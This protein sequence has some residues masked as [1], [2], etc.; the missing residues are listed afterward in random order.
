[1]GTAPA[2][3]YKRQTYVHSLMV[4]ELTRALLQRQIETRPESLVGLLGCRTAAEVQARR[5]EL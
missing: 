3:V 4:A 1:M 2:D 5:G